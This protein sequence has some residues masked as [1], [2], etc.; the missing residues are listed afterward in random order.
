M[1]TAILRE[2]NEAEMSQLEASLRET[3]KWKQYEPVC[4]KLSAILLCQLW[5]A[6]ASE[7]QYSLSRK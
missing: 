1:S 5:L 6:S 3:P 2:A 4:L 7:A